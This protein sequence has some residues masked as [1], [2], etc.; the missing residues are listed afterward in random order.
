MAAVICVV[1]SHGCRHLEA[2]ATMQPL[3]DWAGRATSRLAAWI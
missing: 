3:P 2:Y 1:T